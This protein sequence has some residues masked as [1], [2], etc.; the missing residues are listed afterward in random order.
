MKGGIGG[1]GG[2]GASLNL[3]V[4]FLC[5]TKV[6]GL[7]PHSTGAIKIEHIHNRYVLYMF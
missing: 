2:G 4:V 5:I 1:G 6:Q 3:S 7:N